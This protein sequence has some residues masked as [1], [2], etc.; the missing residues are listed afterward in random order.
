MKPDIVAVCRSR[1]VDGRRCE[2]EKLAF[3]DGINGSQLR[4]LKKF[5]VK[6]L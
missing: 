5:E 4:G 6:K 2:E 3:D 1:E